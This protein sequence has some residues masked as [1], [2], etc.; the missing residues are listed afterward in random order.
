MRLF[1]L[2]EQQKRGYDVIHGL[3]SCYADAYDALH[4]NLKGRSKNCAIIQVTPNEFVSSQQFKER[5]EDDTFV[6][7][8][9]KSGK[10][11]KRMD[12]RQANHEKRA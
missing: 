5:M 9:D 4:V 8:F 12:F 11:I 1:V 10:S 7:L 6:S 2:V 3:F